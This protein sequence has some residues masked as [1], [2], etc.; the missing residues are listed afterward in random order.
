MV[1]SAACVDTGLARDVQQQHSHHRSAH[2]DL[3]TALPAASTP[4][5]AATL[6]ADV[7]TIVHK[8]QPKTPWLIFDALAAC[9][10]RRLTED[11]LKSAFDVKPKTMS[12]YYADFSKQLQSTLHY[13]PDVVDLLA[14][15]R[16]KAIPDTLC[17]L[18]HN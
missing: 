3:I 10:N 17:G 7:A 1:D 14:G 18:L 2:T 8:H 13:A 5:N 15:H 9:W 12:T 16:S 11:P 6:M 4:P